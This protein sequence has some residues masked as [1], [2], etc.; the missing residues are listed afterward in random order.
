M[1]DE[2]E[3]D[4]YFESRPRESQIGAWASVQSQPVE[5]REELDR[6]V[7]EAAVRYPGQ[8]PRPAAW[9]GYRLVPTEIEFWQ[10]RDSRLHDRFLYRLGADGVWLTERLMP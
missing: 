6:R 9:G 8:V 7:G 3:C 1:A 2:A 4:A 5:S 10:G